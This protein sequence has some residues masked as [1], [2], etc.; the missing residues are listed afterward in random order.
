M[1]VSIPGHAVGAIIGKGGGTIDALQAES[2]A[3]LRIPKDQDQGGSER[4]VLITGSDA[5]IDCAQKLLEEKLNREAHA[6]ALRGGKAL[7]RQTQKL[8]ATSI[9][10]QR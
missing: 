5:A 7:K 6:T 3:K 10:E 8:A 1:Q 2:G 4:I 9:V